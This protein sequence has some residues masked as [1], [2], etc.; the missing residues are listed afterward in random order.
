ML[1]LLVMFILLTF[2]NYR[3]LKK[4]GL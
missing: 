2:F 4:E 3:L 1:V